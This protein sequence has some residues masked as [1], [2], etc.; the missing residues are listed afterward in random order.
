MG[1]KKKREVVE[2]PL[3][4]VPIMNLVTILIPFLLMSAQFV[5][6]AVIDSTLPAISSEPAPPDATEEEKL[7]LSVAVTGEG[8]GILGADKV[9]VK[10]DPVN[11]PAI[12]CRDPNCPRPD[13]YDYRELTK[14]LA[15]VKDSYPD[16]A[17][18]I[19]VP[20]GSIPYE[21]I[22]YTMDAAREDVE[23]K[24]ADS[25]PRELFP[26]VVLAAGAN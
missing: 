25:K 4:L 6:I 24:D 19:L 26:F 10:D 1:K 8:F 5:T 14:R 2:Q 12:P 3:D 20:E 17:N 23:D 18:V 15:L 13:S 16:E 22:V 11:G 21:V 9:L 7:T